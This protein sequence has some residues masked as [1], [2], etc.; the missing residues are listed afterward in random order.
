MNTIEI[1]V[2]LVADVAKYFAKWANEQLKKNVVKNDT[3][4][5]IEALSSFSTAYI[6]YAQDTIGKMVY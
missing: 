1:Q 5:M 6:H 3:G 2:D 4:I